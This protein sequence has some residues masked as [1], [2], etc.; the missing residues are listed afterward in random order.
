MLALYGSR[1]TA[2]QG[3][4]AEILLD[5][6]RGLAGIIL[7]QPDPSLTRHQP[8]RDPVDHEKQ[9]KAFLLL[10]LTTSLS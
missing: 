2:E 7:E 8:V 5:K 10:L 3:P 9:L 4:T 6:I 1:T